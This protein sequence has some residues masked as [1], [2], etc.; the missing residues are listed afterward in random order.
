MIKRNR[1]IIIKDVHAAHHDFLVKNVAAAASCRDF[2][3]VIVVATV[4]IVIVVIKLIY[5]RLV[6]QAIT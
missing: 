1:S 5:Q 6:L 2:T 4:K 3:Y